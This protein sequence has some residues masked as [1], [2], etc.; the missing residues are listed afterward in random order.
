MN[1]IAT[2]DAAKDC[3]TIGKFSALW[4]KVSRSVQAAKVVKDELEAALIVP[5][6]T[7]WNSYYDAVSKV[8]GIAVRAESKLRAVC[9]S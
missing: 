9:Q 8:C 6:E 2:H 3:S 4:N 1:L 7:C 5:S